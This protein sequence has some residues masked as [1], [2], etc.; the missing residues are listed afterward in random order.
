MEGYKGKIDTLFVCS[1]N[2]IQFVYNI[3]NKHASAQSNVLSDVA[4][5]LFIICSKLCKKLQNT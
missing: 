2:A 1:A 3:N 5:A 4:M